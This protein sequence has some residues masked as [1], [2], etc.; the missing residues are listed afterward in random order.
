MFHNNHFSDLD[1]PSKPEVTRREATAALAL[2]A[3]P[4]SGDSWSLAPS[5]PGQSPAERAEVEERCY[6]LLLV[7][8]EIETTPAQ[9]LQRLD[10]AARLHPSPTRAYL[11]RGHP[12][13]NGRVTKR[14]P[15]GSGA[16]RRA[17][18]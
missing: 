2:Y 12:A 14:R 5:R 1:L 6:E 11:R 3:A 13:W 15:R 16:R 10:Q 9:G 8:A 18:R 7:L 4:G 17:G